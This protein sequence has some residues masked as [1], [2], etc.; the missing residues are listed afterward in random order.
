M[1]QTGRE[2]PARDLDM[3]GLLTLSPLG[4]GH[5]RGDVPAAASGADEP[6]APLGDRGIDAVPLGHLG[7]VRLDLMTA[8]LT[9]DNQTPQLRC[10]AS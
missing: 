8:R 1:A 3:A 6:L 9:P 10:A 7:G 2:R 5:H 4:P